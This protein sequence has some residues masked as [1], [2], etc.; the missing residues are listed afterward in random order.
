MRSSLS[1]ILKQETRLESRYEGHIT[2]IIKVSQCNKSTTVGG[3]LLPSI[4]M[5]VSKGPQCNTK[6]LNKTQDN[7]ERKEFNFAWLH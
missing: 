5:Y 6:K 2:L 1:P 4:M 3:C 7:H